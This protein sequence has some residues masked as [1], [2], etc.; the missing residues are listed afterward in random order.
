MTR[1]PGKAVQV[2][3][4]LL[5]FFGG[6]EHWH[7][8]EFRDGRGS[9][10]LVGPLHHVRRQ[11]RITGDGAGFYLR[12][13]MPRPIELAGYNDERAR[14]LELQ[15]LVVLARRMATADQASRP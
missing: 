12:R 1:D 11:H 9:R 14:F 13:A 4:L 10:C 6:G 8:G 2:F 7:Q 15:A 3:D 5:Q